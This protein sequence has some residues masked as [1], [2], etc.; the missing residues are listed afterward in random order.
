[1][2]NQ[3]VF[4]DAPSIVDQ[5]WS[6][7]PFLIGHAAIDYENGPTCVLGDV[8]RLARSGAISQEQVECIFAFFNDVAE[9]GDNSALDVLA[10][11]ALESMNDDAASQ[12]LAR[13]YLRGKALGLLEEMRISWGQPD[14]GEAS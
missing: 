2:S 6:A 14:H 11:G 3:F 8:S 9:R 7:C 5:M 13:R 1:M 12:R 10:T 4:S